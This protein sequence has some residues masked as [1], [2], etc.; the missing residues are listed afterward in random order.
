VGLQQTKNRSI[1]AQLRQQSPC[2]FPAPSS[3]KTAGSTISP[4]QAHKWGKKQYSQEDDNALALNKAGK[5]FIQE[6][7]GVFLYLPRAVDGG[8]LKV[9]SSLA[10]QQANPT[11]KTIELCKQFLDYMG[12]GELSFLA[13]FS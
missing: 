12:R 2:P 6:V 10:S 8:L 9:L 3:T 13:V 5:K 4:W 1:N 11:E 7:C